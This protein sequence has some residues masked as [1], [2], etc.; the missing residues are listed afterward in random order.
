MIIQIVFQFVIRR[1]IVMYLGELY[2][3]LSSLYTS[4]LGVL[5]IAELGFSTSITYFMY[6]PL[7]ENNIEYVSCL[8]GYLKKIYSFVGVAILS[9][10]L[11]LTPA[12]TF[13]IKSDVPN[14]INVYLLFF[15]YLVNTSLGYLLYAYKTALLTALQRLD[16]I[17]IANCIILLIQY[18]LQ[19]ISIA[20]FKNYYLFVCI[21]IGGTI[22]TNIFISF[23]CKKNFPEYICSSNIDCLS[24]REII[25]KVKGLIVCNISS[26]T[27]S[28]FDSI[29]ISSL[30]GLS[31]VTIYNNYITVFSGISSL[32]FV[33]RN[34]MQASVG[35]SVA[36]ESIDKNYK[37]VKLWQFAF[38]IICM[39]C[40]SCLVCL[41]Q[42]F[43]KLWMGDELLLTMKDVWAIGIWFMVSNVQNSFYLYLSADGLFNEM[44]W[45]YIGS[46]IFN[47]IGNIILGK[48]F[49]V[50]GVIV[51]SVLSCF[52]FG[53]LWQCILIFKHYFHKSALRYIFIQLLYLFC[54]LII[55]F[56]SYTLCKLVV[57][58][59]INGLILKLVI[60]IFSTILL[61]FIM[62]YKSPYTSRLKDLLFKM[63]KTS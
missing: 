36:S 31:T 16:I 50:T 26:V 29:I 49:G 22:F 5:N 14:D 43:M 45:P 44:K 19:L 52:I 59:S 11:F 12:I 47:I 4:I 35:N 20:I 1:I 41:F 60:C 7:A 51:S 62:F 46:T 24:K 21:M 6:K 10:G 27:Y 15:M 30:I 63:I 39:F 61:I 2:L 57:I 40:M 33:I 48:F 28:S 55:T 9:I 17:K 34:A 23:L 8:L 58:E 32:V 42:P 13:F 37:D 38:S 54:S 25:R 3:G 18:I 56:V 53:S